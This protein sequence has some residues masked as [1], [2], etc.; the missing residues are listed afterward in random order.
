MVY[1]TQTRAS[2]CASAFVRSD[3]LSWDTGGGGAELAFTRYCKQINRTHT[4]TPTDNNTPDT[5][6]HTH[7]TRTTPQTPK[8]TPTRHCDSQYCM[9]YS[10]QTR[11]SSCASAFV[12][13]DALSWD[14]GEGGGVGLVRSV[15]C[16]FHVHTGTTRGHNPWGR[17]THRSQI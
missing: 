11:A 10:T 6:T 12:R 17:A 4:H 8:R 5:N 3:A 1:S 14:T 16:V 7:T 15:I 13:S 9:V 2:S